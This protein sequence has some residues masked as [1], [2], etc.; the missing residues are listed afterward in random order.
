MEIKS[1]PTIPEIEGGHSVIFFDLP[2][3]MQQRF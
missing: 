3:Q 2:L 1:C